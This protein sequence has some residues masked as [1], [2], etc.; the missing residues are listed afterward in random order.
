MK[1]SRLPG[2]ER[3]GTAPAG[4]MGGMGG[5]GMNGCGADTFRE[6][7]FRLLHMESQVQEA[8]SAL[9]R[10]HVQHEADRQR[11]ETLE[12]ELGE[13]QGALG[14][15]QA[16]LQEEQA[17]AAEQAAAAAAREAALQSTLKAVRL[18]LSEQRAP[19]KLNTRG[20]SSFND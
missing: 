1:M 12:I 8:Q 15:A 16:S 3:P 18:Q 4:G 17:R 10:K 20:V 19:R 2:H 7:E 9:A 13:A 5:E 6:M 14:K 11:A